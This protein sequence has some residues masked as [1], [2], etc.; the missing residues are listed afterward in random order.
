MIV[1]QKSNSSDAFKKEIMIEQNQIIGKLEAKELE[2]KF[3]RAIQ[4]RYSDRTNSEKESI[5]KRNEFIDSQFEFTPKVCEKI[6]LLN[7]KLREEEKRIFY[8][9]RK[10][11]EQCKLMV[12][13]KEI[14]DFNIDLELAFWN[15]KHYKKFNPE[16]YDIPFFQSTDSFMVMQMFEVEYNPEPKNEHCRKSPFKEFNEISHCYTFHSLYDHCHELTWFD[17]YNIDQ[18]WMEIKVDYQFFRKVK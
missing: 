7:E 17:I 18:F 5:E 10:I 13:N 3:I 8:Q 15:N 2:L 12:K 4:K 11:E 1:A 6:I 14:D 16:V 9:Y